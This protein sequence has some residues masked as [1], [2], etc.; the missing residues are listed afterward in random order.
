MRSLVAEI[1]AVYRRAGGEPPWSSI[2]DALPPEHAADLRDAISLDAEARRLLGLRCDPERWTPHLPDG[3]ARSQA[4]DALVGAVLEG[5]TDDGRFAEACRML[6]ARGPDFAAAVARFRLVHEMLREVTGDD[7][8]DDPEPPDPPCDFGPFLRDGQHRFRLLRRL[9]AGGSGT[10]YEAIDRRFGDEGYEH[11]VVV[12]ILRSSQAHRAEE[13]IRRGSRVRHEGV[14]R[15]IDWGRS[16][17]G[18]AFVVSELVP[19]ASLAELRTLQRLGRR[20]VA[21][22]LRQIALALDAIHAAG[23]L[24]MDVKPANILVDDGGAAR[25]CDFGAAVPL[26]GAVGGSAATPVFAAPEVL[27]GEVPTPAADIYALGAVLRWCMDELD[28]IGIAPLAADD[29]A[30]LEQIWTHAMAGTPDRRY[31]RA[32]A[33]A[34]DLGA[35]L[36]RR[37]LSIEAPS[38]VESVRLSMRRDPLTWS[39]A[40]ATVFAVAAL[41]WIWIDERIAEANRRSERLLQESR[42]LRAQ[43]ELGRYIDRLGMLAR[44]DG[45]AAAPQVLALQ[46]LVGARGIDSAELHARA[47]DAQREVWRSIVAAAEE[48]GT[49]DRLEPRLAELSLAVVDLRDRR[50]G[51]VRDRLRGA[52][53]WWQSR[54]EAD[55]PIVEIA[56][57]LAELAEAGSTEPA[58]GAERRQR[59]ARLEEIRESMRTLAPSLAR[60]A[61]GMILELNRRRGP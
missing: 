26:H 21:S 29:A 35:W 20:G 15:W 11:R 52:L 28:E 61:E 3:A 55:D 56:R 42:R 58:T 46:W 59:V 57:T 23:I 37:P 60:I 7:A 16:S 22:V 19:A 24:H 13:E 25:L 31:E 6:A 47:L 1:L 54:L 36:D 8:P 43:A 34:H 40:A 17:C 27:E 51:S 14:V 2:L 33:M 10:A 53:P 39:L 9:G 12:K 44:S 4:L 45:I 5:E 32:R 49:M 18:A 48:R 38:L 50:Y 30:R 41:A